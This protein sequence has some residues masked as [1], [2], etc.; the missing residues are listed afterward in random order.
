MALSLSGLALRW[1]MGQE[2]LRPR[3]G[4]KIFKV[5]QQ[6]TSKTKVSKS[7]EATG[8]KGPQQ[9]EGVGEKS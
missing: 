3:E 1:Q 2:T 5:I 8:T 4:R 7:S 9:V 6:V